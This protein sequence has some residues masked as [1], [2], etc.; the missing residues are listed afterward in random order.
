MYGP[1]WTAW[2]STSFD[3]LKKASQIVDITGNFEKLSKI[4]DSYGQ[5]HKYNA[6]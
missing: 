1:N 5:K 3:E 6:S 2:N 4:Y